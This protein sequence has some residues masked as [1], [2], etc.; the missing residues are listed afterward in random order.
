MRLHS[1]MFGTK[2]E[3]KR[4]RLRRRERIENKTTDR[5]KESELKKERK[6]GETTHIV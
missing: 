4:K 1:G 3:A 5:E 6:S 2:L